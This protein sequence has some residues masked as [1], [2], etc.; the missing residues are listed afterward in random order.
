MAS[1]TSTDYQAVQR[2]LGRGL[3]T[4]REDCPPLET[5]RVLLSYDGN[6]QRLVGVRRDGERAVYFQESSREGVSVGFDGDGLN[7]SG[8]RP[9]A[10]LSPSTSIGLWVEKTRYHWGWRHPRYR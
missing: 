3:R 10:N 6:G 2:D 9:I 1:A 8:G 5:A 7:G 4:L